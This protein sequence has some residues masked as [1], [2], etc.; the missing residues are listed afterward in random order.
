MFCSCK[1]SGRDWFAIL[2]RLTGLSLE[3]LFTHCVWPAQ[4]LNGMRSISPKRRSRSR[5]HRASHSCEYRILRVADILFASHRDDDA[6]RI[7]SEVVYKKINHFANL[8]RPRLLRRILRKQNPFFANLARP[9]LLKICRTSFIWFRKQNQTR[10]TDFRR[11]WT[12]PQKQLRWFALINNE[13]DIVFVFLQKRHCWIWGSLENLCC[14][15]Q[16]CRTHVIFRQTGVLHW[17][18]ASLR[19]GWL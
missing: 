11:L 8:V 14:G 2:P 9:T 10:T 3:T 7:C 17:H 19:R 1:V 15:H 6:F 13:S 18:L 12:V 5:A 4:E 16:T